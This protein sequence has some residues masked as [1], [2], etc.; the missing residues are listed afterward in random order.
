MIRFGAVYAF[1]VVATAALG[2]AGYAAIHSGAADPAS[3]G[4]QASVLLGATIT[5]L[6]DLVCRMVLIV[7]TIVWIVSAHRLRPAGPGIL[8]YLAMTAFLLLVGLTY[9][10][11]VRVSSVNGSIVVQAALDVAGIVILIAGVILVRSRIRTETG[12]EIP[13]RHRTM[14]V[15]SDDWNASKWDPEVLGDIERRRGGEAR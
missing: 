7:S 4:T 8:G 2:L 13:S 14:Q 15:S 6:V 1:V 3:V 9:L 12:L 11:P 5:G 10:L